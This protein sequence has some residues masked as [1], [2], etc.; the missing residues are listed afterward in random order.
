[1]HFGKKKGID[2]WEITH[3]K[4]LGFLE[5]MLQLHLSRASAFFNCPEITCQEKWH[6]NVMEAWQYLLSTERKLNSLLRS[7]FSMLL[8]RRMRSGSASPKFPARRNALG[9]CQI[10]V[11]SVAGKDSKMAD[12]LFVFSERISIPCSSV[13]RMRSLKPPVQGLFLLYSSAFTVFKSGGVQRCRCQS[14]RPSYTS[15]Y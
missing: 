10:T 9:E 6:R 13:W 3:T 12:S 2:P 7:N 14:A 8:P 1:M 11:L 15:V 5:R 4:E